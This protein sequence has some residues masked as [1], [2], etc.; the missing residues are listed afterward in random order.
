MIRYA[1]FAILLIFVKALV[2]TTA[3]LLALPAA[4]FKFTGYVGWFALVHTHDDDIYGSITTGDP[5]PSRFIDRWKRATWWLMRNPAYGFS[6]RVLGIP[7]S[8]VARTAHGGQLLSGATDT[9][10]LVDG[11]I[12]WGYRRDWHYGSSKRYCKIW[13]GYHWKPQGRAEKFHSFK[14]DFNP[15]K[16]D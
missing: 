16:K 13:F 8:Q 4:L 14:A 10:I 6:A 3:P 1:W 15:F 12:E 9:L 7:A 2:F 11:S 5:V